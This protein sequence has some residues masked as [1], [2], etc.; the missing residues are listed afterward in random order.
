ML[1]GS[2]ATAALRLLL[3]DLAGSGG[4]GALHVGGHPGGSLYL[5]NGLITYA[6]SPAHPD[7]RERLVTTGRLSEET[8]R[9]A[10]AAG[11]ADQ[12][13]GALLVQQGHLVPGELACRVLAAICDATDA[14]LR[15]DDAPV[16]FVPDERHWL[17][18]VAQLELTAL[19]RETARRQHESAFPTAPGNPPAGTAHPGTGQQA[20]AGQAAAGQ[21]GNGQA[22]V[23]AALPLSGRPAAAQ[24][25]SDGPWAGTIRAERAGQPSP[26]SLPSRRA[27]AR[28][29]NAGPRDDGG[30]SD[31]DNERRPSPDYATLKRIRSALKS[32]W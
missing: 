18:P 26:N 14:L 9:A 21:A 29:T 11:F 23:A 27:G 1:T 25:T 8:W 32:N 28:P 31:G 12:Q 20:A 24:S 5:L 4:T 30:G 22:A 2:P 6:E 7:I 19:I 16:S 15:S 10:F 3:T 13:V 17:G